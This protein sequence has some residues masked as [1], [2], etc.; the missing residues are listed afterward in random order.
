M[1]TKIRP[2]ARPAWRRKLAS[3]AVA[4]AV[5]LTALTGGVLASPEPA[6]AAGAPG[7]GGY[8]TPAGGWLGNYIAANGTRVYCIDVLIDSIGSGGDAGNVSSS[9]SP[10]SGTRAVSGAE[11]QMMNYAITV[12]GQT[13]DPVTAAAVSAY[14]Y[15]FTSQNWYGNGAHYISGPNSGAILSAYNA[16][17]ADTA[18]NYNAGSGSGTGVMSF[19]VDP[20]NNYLGTLNVTGLSPAGAVG[21]VTLTNGVF[22]DT[23]LATRDGVTNN[24]SYPVVGVPPTDDTVEYKI[25]AQG[26]FTA[27][28]GYASNVRIH[29][30]A[31][32]RTAGPGER[33]GS[34]FNLVASDPAPR[35]TKFL[36]VVGTRVAS[37]LLAEGEE[38]V[39]VLTFSTAPDANGV[40]N[41][42]RTRNQGTMFAQITGRGS[43]YFTGVTPPVEAD[44]PPAN[45]MLV[46]SDI[47][48]TT[49]A[50]GGPNIEYTV[51]SGYVAE[52]PGYYTWVWE[53][54]QSDQTASSPNV[55]QLLPEGYHFKDR[56][57]Q[58][59]ETSIA[60][61]NL[62]I[63][64][65]LTKTE[66]GIGQQVADQVT[67]Q[68]H[69][70][71]WIQADGGRVPVTLTGTA[72]YS[73][74]LPELSDTPPTDAEVV[75][76][77]SL[78]A[79]KPGTTE[80]SSITLPLKEGYVTFQWCI[81]E[82]NQPAEYQGMIK[83]SC[84][85]YGQT[86][87]TVKLI[88][89]TVTTQAKEIATIHDPIFDTAFVDGPVP[90]DTVLVFELYK[91]P[92]VG[93]HKY[94]D[95]EISDEV[96][97]QDEL[98]ELGDD[99]LCTVSNRVTRTDSVSV[100][101]G[102]ND[103]VSYDSPTVM[104]DSTGV[105]WWVES[106]IH[107]PSETVIR[108]GECGL[109]NETTKVEEPTVTTKAVQ[110]VYTDEK[111]AFDTAIVTGPI[112]GADTGIRAE[113]TFRVYEAKYVNGVA[114]CDASNLIHNLDTP[115]VVTG[116]GEYKSEKV[117]LDK[118]K[119]HWQEVFTY[120]FPNGDKE[121]VHEGECGLENETT[122][123]KVRPVLALTGS[124]GAPTGLAYGLGVAGL[125]AVLGAAAFF[126]VRRRSQLA[127]VQAA[128]SIRDCQG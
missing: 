83:E 89:P 31:P 22:T 49:T 26:A 86:S 18:A 84:D 47:M 3:L 40:N 85:K 102:D 119:N 110:T 114:V 106:L 34:N 21:S 79:N 36:P 23:G 99:A 32:Q 16:I 94:V 80:S 100:A 123:S 76:N 5:A 87:E 58:V 71:G 61:S 64:T 12:H 30:D 57:G 51:P 115:I 24:S 112:P 111:E 75:G 62:A 81:V 88:A 77:L 91:K 28:G 2:P 56:F 33:S 126:V 122:Y 39:D 104:V 125:L 14:V 113:L 68:P 1:N 105:Y 121:V 43:I 124:T 6:N 9:I 35:S 109:P 78:T 92:A 29:S 117:Q 66:A 120:V 128:D 17:A 50:E 82:A 11:L 116:A 42:W 67:V 53:I 108:A 74:T 10:E 96:W 13:G 93:D 73:P 48:V 90:D 7:A 38:L 70:G 4:A 118:P 95:G 37:K 69:G 54:L 59:V 52:E 101:A 8:W 27:V 103:G 46:A 44:E 72:Y 20:A 41:P 45:A 107:V 60:P 97:T 25:S 127:A 65:E 55:Q 98:D 63:S 19:A 15:N